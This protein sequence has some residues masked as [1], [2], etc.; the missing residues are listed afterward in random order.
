MSY[1]VLRWKFITL[2]IVTVSLA[3]LREAFDNRFLR[4]AA[5]KLR[6]VLDIARHRIVCGVFM[7]Q[8]VAGELGDGMKVEFF[9]D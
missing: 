8:P 5:R 4:G 2:P 6:L 1:G 7:F 9:L 3:V